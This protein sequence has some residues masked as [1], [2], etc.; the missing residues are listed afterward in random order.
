VSITY[1]RF[2]AKDKLKRYNTLTLIIGITMPK[3]LSKFTKAE[4]QA[5]AITKRMFVRKRFS[6][7]IRILGPGV[8]T[9]AADD[10]PSGIATYSQAGA[11]YGLGFLWAFPFMYPLL[12]AVQESCSRIGAVTGMGL[13][14]VIKQNYSKKILYMSVLLV[15]VANTINIGSDLGA[16]AATTQLF[17]NLPFAVLVVFY[18]VVVILL[19]IFV[20]YKKYVTILKWLALT[21]LAYPV[22]VFLVGQNWNDVFI[23]TFATAPTINAD[24]IYI[25]VG[26]LGTTISPYLFFWDTSEVVEEEIS[27]HR[28]AQS[29]G[30]PKISHHFLKGIRIDNFVGMTLAT[31][32]AWFIVIACAS[33]LFK[34]GITNINT[35]SDAAQALQ[36]LVK[37]FPY[38]GL[39]AKIVFSVGIIGIGLLAVP[40][41]AGSSSYAISETLGWKEGLYRKFR[42]AYGFYI[43]IIISTVIGVLINFVGIDPIKALVFTA[44]F[45][46]IAAVPLL[47]MIARVGNNRDIMG[48]YKNGLI[49]N[50]FVRIAL[51][52]MAIAVIALFF[53]MFKH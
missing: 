20:N 35:A 11:A 46:G 1:P 15:V 24:T 42:K 25:L 27:E 4:R 18:A 41:L 29:G 9:G 37:N 3:K 5:K 34:N 12:L 43:V 28:Q 7:F 52:V 17:V 23:H 50:I 2:I 40:V 45:N 39:I 22:T 13:A 31:L 19:I 33:V 32:T 36:P 44:V 53:F 47:W 21:L 6:R 10:D 30:T 51:V 48:E 14:A 26:I 16:M 8:V 49:S 38:S